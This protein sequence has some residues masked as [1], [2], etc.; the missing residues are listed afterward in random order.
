MYSKQHTMIK[1][2]FSDSQFST[3]PPTTELQFNWNIVETIVLINLPPPPINGKI[4]LV[5]NSEITQTDHG[6]GSSG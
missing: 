5:A 2:F 4:V 1:F 6:Q 3:F